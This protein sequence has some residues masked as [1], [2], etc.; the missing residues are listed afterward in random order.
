MKSFICNVH[1]KRDDAVHD[2]HRREE[3]FKLQNEQSFN[4]KL[5]INELEQKTRR[6]R[7]Y[8]YKFQKRR[9]R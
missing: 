1:I 9:R 6:R 7:S 2:F 3:S 8:K 5:L 4:H